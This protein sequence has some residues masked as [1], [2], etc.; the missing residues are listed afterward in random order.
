MKKFA[1]YI[2]NHSALVVIISLVLLIPAIIGYVNTR[3]NYDILVYLPDSVDTIKGENILTDD[4]GLGAYAFVMVDSNNSKNIL[5]LEKD[6][7]KIDGVNA[8]VSLADLTDTTIPVD[9]LP[10]KVV[11]KLDKDNETIA[12]QSE[13]NN[14]EPTKNTTTTNNVNDEPHINIATEEIKKALKDKNWINSHLLTDS[15]NFQDGTK[16]LT[17]ICLKKDTNSSPI[18]IAEEFIENSQAYI[19]M[20]K[21]YL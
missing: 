4:F 11:D 3:I 10:S 13:N 14:S 16:K 21:N 1:N 2:A 19:D 18:I 8:V 7:K 20:W 15:E 9:M 5:N 17:F 12:N 6:I